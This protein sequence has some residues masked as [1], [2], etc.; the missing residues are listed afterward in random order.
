MKQTLHVSIGGYPFTI[1]KEAYDKL[2]IYLDDVAA[3]YEGD[4]D[5]EEIMKELEERTA[6]LILEKVGKGNVAG[7]E[8]V[9]YA[10]GR[11]GRP[12]ELADDEKNQV[13]GHREAQNGQ[14][15]GMRGK[16]L[17]RDVDNRLLGGVCSGIAAYFGVDVVLV[18]IAFVVLFAPGFILQ[19]FFAI[20]II[21]Y[22]LLWLIVPAA[23]S[24]EEKC[25]MRGKPL[26]LGEF[27]QKAP[28]QIREVGKEMQTSPA[29]HTAGKVISIILGTVLILIGTG[30]L[31][32][33]FVMW[34]M[35]DLIQAIIAK[36]GPVIQPGNINMTVMG[37][38]N[39]QTTWLLIGIITGIMSVWAIYVGT[40]CTFG[41]KAP[42]WKPGLILFLLWIVAILVFGGYAFKVLAI[43]AI[44][45]TV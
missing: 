12:D 6:E 22:M 37:F 16:R 10:I 36:H 39:M 1:E 30:G 2:K 34:S 7:E 25:R 9:K 45:L 3:A 13:E 4:S 24:V 41:F 14:G 29:I 8:A 31:F 28:G 35:P 21:A 5:A 18:R 15:T 40:M 43:P 38:L 19:Q 27:K 17:Y 33:C 20:S 44:M 23:K 32:G 42:K 26:D 11:I